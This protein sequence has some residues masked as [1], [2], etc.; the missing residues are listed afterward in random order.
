MYDTV[1][2]SEPNELIVDSVMINNVS[3]NGLNDGFANFSLTGGSVPYTIDW[4]GVNPFFLSAGS[5]SVL[6]ID[7]TDV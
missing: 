5:Y 4:G 1:T 2:I 3:C 6:I 7:L